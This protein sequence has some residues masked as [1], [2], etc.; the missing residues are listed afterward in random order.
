MLGARCSTFQ[1]TVIMGLTAEAVGKT[2]ASAM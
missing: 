2:E 1:L